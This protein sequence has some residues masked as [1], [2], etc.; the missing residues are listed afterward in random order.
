MYSPF[1]SLHFKVHISG[2]KNLNELSKH[3]DLDKI[4]AIVGGKC[5]G[6]VF[7]RLECGGVTYVCVF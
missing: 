6:P 4:P 7:E 2:K 3:I 5:E 1:L